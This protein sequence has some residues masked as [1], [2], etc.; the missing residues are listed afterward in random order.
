MF[1]NITQQAAFALLQ[2]DA[3]FI[4]TLTDIQKNAYNI[5]S[6]Y[7]M[8]CQPYVGI[9]ADGA[10][11]WAKKVG[12]NSP[13]FNNKEKA[14]YAALRQGHKLLEK[15]YNTYSKLLRAHLSRVIYTIDKIPSKFS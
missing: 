12:L 10:E 15:P 13:A 6:N 5:K 9:F 8:M 3:R 1:L 14:Y 4:Y 2:S 11:Q 7:I